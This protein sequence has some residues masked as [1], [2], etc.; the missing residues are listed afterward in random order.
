M[1]IYKKL[2]PS[3]ITLVI[4]MVLLSSCVGDKK[5]KKQEADAPPPAS[6]KQS[7]QQRTVIEPGLL[8][9]RFQ[10][11]GYMLSDQ[12][13][14]S[15]EEDTAD[16]MK[17]FQ[18]QVGANVSTTEPIPLRDAMKA[19]ARDKD[20]SLSWASD[21]DPSLLVDIDV[22]SDDDFFEAIDNILRQLDYFHEMEG[23]TMIVK[24][25]QTKQ[26]HIAMPFV[27]HQFDTATGGNLFG[28]GDT[29]ISKSTEGTIRLKSEENIFD[30]WDNIE[31][32][33]AT[34]IA[35]WSSSI[36][37]S[38]ATTE[39][40][41]EEDDK[42]KE[43]S[44]S[45]SSRRVSST[46]SSYT[47]DK[48]VGLITI[49]AP[50][51]LQ[52]RIANYLRILEKE[53]YKQIMIE[54]KIIEVQLRDN[55]SL[56][57]NWQ[58]LLKNLSISPG[59]FLADKDRYKKTDESSDESSESENKYND[60]STRASSSS[61]SDSYGSAGSATQSQS[62]TSGD[63][64]ITD[65]SSTNFGSSGSTS[66][67]SS[68]FSGRNIT[69][70]LETITSAAST[71]ATL[72]TG[73]TASAAYGGFFIAGFTFESFFNALKKQGKTSVLSNPKISV[74]NGQ[75]A[76]ITVGRNVTYVRAVETDIDP[77]T[78]IKTYTLKTDD[79]LS[80]VGL[81]ISAVVKGND[82]VVM[83]L[84]PVT[85]ELV[86][87][88]EYMEISDFKVGLPVV[89]VREMSTTVT[90]KNGSILVVGGL[91]SDTED[92]EGDFLYGTEDIP[93]LKYLFGYEEKKRTKRELII[94]LR[95]YIVN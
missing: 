9:T 26:Y 2:L 77:E 67:S 90:I 8:P 16:L 85:S 23:S 32:N 47:I 64:G 50:Q 4:S 94:L 74:M 43:T 76:M 52:K 31:K 49:H 34:I 92:K 55:S 84:V 60:I 42:D 17:N 1:K 62:L 79:I 56:G 87:D 82:E 61:N 53:L 29:D 58:T 83:N 21:V 95:P 28:G 40:E 66:D 69:N 88:I 80:G 14:K 18:L 25:R 10:Q 65:S 33:I 19:L 54:A 70:S 59:Y 3:C 51:S 13:S 86:E 30:I 93:Y 63:D 72:L 27:K 39:D 73:S 22:S 81:A 35:T 24:Y 36:A 37:N 48:P 12:N 68:N 38:G 44:T 46:D 41:E 71:A 5:N 15:S 57:I 7:A 91:I 45:S 75:P 20:M 6:N 89:N 11:A 78:R